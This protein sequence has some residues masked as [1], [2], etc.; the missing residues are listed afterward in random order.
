MKILLLLLSFVSVAKA[1]IYVH[2]LWQKQEVSV[3][4]GKAEEKS[5][6]FLGKEFSIHNWSKTDQNK[7]KTWVMEEYSQERT[8][9]HFVGWTD[10]EEA[11]DADVVVLFHKNSP[12]LANT[13]N[14][15]HG[16]TFYSGPSFGTIDGYPH[17]SNLVIIS[18]SGVDKTTATHEFGHV[19][20]LMHEH[21]HP[22]IKKFD[23]SCKF[24]DPKFD[25]RIGYEDY[26]KS[27][28]MNYCFALKNRNSGLS[29]KDVSL[30]KRL[31]H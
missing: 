18:K 13:F 12:V 8:G 26:D 5:R 10:C 1:N 30:L 23:E 11:P 3:C 9:I 27:S 4:F 6:F 7:I 31:Y 20:G 24:A 16:A 14:G 17:A 25:S 19:A 22:D 2:Q 28:V 29:E 21:N 15:I